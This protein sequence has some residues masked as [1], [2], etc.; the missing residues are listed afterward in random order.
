M[1]MVEITA[2]NVV[3]WWF[4][5]LDR[6]HSARVTENPGLAGFILQMKNVLGKPSILLTTA[7]LQ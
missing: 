3:K 7:V 5:V 1:L 4:G 2:V 6:A